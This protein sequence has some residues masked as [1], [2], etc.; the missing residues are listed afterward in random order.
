M[1]GVIKIII[2]MCIWG[3]LGVFVK[4]ISLESFEVAFLRAVIA[5]VIVGVVYFIKSKEEKDKI[6]YSD[7]DVNKK[8]KKN[9]IILIVSGILIGF[10]WVLLFKSYN[11]TTISNATLGYYFAPVMVVFLSP[12]ILKERFT[13][14]VGLSVIAAMLGLFLILNSQTGTSIGEFNHIK[15]ITIALCAAGLYASVMLLNKYIQGI[16]D[17]ERTFIQLFSAAVVLLP[18]IIYRNC[19]RIID[20][21]SLV[22]I[23]ILGI[24]HTGI[25]YCL[26]FSAIK[27][28][29]AQTA[30]LLSY[31]DPV[32]AI[33]FSV[34]FLGEPLSVMQ[35]IGG[36]I[37]LSS[38]YIAQKSP[39]KATT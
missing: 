13:L 2:A 9:I 20:V 14:K 16:G 8:S 23:L 17:Y 38:A 36:A 18:F 26:Y 19:L 5:T 34:V 31:I 12:I 11:Y 24:V 30:A 37:I 15:G 25:A 28:I 7:E 39:Q 32:S 35:V 27:D 29:K 1:S 3:S 33:F 10:N 21:K 4:N 22:F 6:K